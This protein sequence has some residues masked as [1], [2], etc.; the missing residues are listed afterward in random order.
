MLDVEEL[1]LTLT[2]LHTH[3]MPVQRHRMLVLLSGSAMS[4]ECQRT[5][6][7]VNGGTFMV[8][9]STIPRN[10]YLTHGS[11]LLHRTE[12]YIAAD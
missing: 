11:A 4:G 6:R 12:W 10:A 1:E 9:H 7:D 8:G 3:A 5:A 2:Y